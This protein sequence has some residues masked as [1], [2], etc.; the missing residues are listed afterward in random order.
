MVQ[1]SMDNFEGH[2]KGSRIAWISHKATGR[3]PG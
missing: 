2:R 3:D 1:D